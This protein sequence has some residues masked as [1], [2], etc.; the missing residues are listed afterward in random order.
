MR[1]TR[2]VRTGGGCLMGSRSV[3]LVVD[4]VDVGDLRPD[5]FNPR[6]ISDHEMEALTRSIQEFGLVDPI[7]ARREDSTVIGGHQRLLAARRLGLKTAPVIFVDVSTEQARL[8]NLALNKIAGS[9]DQELLA[10]LMV[11]L[12]A[13]PN[14][15]LSLSG[16]G[17]DEIA[18]LLKSLDAREKRHQEESFD[19]D[20]ALTA[21]R[22]DTG[23]KRG[24][25][26]LLGDHR[27]MCGDS[28][29]SADVA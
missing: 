13:S 2:T 6:R 7:I 14:V 8:L 28:A 27:L 22:A 1:S 23:V 25:I 11:D 29:D 4:E 24:D 18:K 3:G 9:W 5:P 20:A 26:W 12:S 16:F 21:A 19:L 15:D 17:E 10:R